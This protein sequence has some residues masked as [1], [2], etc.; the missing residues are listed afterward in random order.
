MKG[1]LE[2]HKGGKSASIGYEEEMRSNG[3]KKQIK[4]SRRTWIGRP[5]SNAAKKLCHPG[6]PKVKGE[7][8]SEN[9][10]TKTRLGKCGN[11]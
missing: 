2:D 6:F 5:V 4:K 7:R 3:K 8:A 10:K 9:E 11:N 1:S